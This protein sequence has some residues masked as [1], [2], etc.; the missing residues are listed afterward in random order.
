MNKYDLGNQFKENLERLPSLTL[1]QK[2][3]L[4][5]NLANEEGD[6]DIEIIKAIIRTKPVFDLFLREDKDLK[7]KTKIKAEINRLQKFFNQ[8]QILDLCEFMNAFDPFYREVKEGILSPSEEIESIKV[9]GKTQD[10]EFLENDSVEIINK[11]D[12]LDKLK[13][14][15]A[16]LGGIIGLIFAFIF[17]EIV[18]LNL[19]FW[20]RISKAELSVGALKLLTLGSWFIAALIFISYSYLIIDVFSK[21]EQII[22]TSLKDYQRRRK[23]TKPWVIGVLVGA[24]SPILF[25][26]IYSIRHKDWRLFIY[27]LWIYFSLSFLVIPFFIDSNFVKIISQIS[28]GLIAYLIVRKNKITLKKIN[29]EV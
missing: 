21:A 6:N 22:V 27:P 28:S 17:K 18:E 10:N 3:E 12:V 20:L 9:D 14:F 29:S 11:N 2:V 19:Y 7:E 5:E 24:L 1:N 16:S 25:S 13:K 23:T 26:I 15:G 4:L 8:D